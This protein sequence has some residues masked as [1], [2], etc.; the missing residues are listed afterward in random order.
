MPSQL[1]C[2]STH[3]LYNRFGSPCPLQGE[4]SAPTTRCIYRN[5]RARTE[6][7]NKKY[8]NNNSSSSSSSNNNNNNNNATT[9]NNKN[10][11]SNK[12][13]HFVTLLTMR[14]IIIFA[15]IQ[16]MVSG[17][18]DNKAAL[19][20]ART[21]LSWIRAPPPAHQPESLRSPC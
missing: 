1:D 18:V 12:K 21:L 3:E 8:N 2:P 6:K 19:R 9:N 13:Q 11:D 20:F 4:H 10:Y 16:R 15:L 7:D 5:D 14:K 17:T